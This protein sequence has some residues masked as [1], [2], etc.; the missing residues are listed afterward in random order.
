MQIG[1]TATAWECAWRRIPQGR[2][3]RGFL[4]LKYRLIERAIIGKLAGLGSGRRA[5][6]FF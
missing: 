6:G 2:A 5:A 3:C 1:F 4:C